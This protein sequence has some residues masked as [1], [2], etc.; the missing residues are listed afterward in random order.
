MNYNTSVFLVQWLMHTAPK[1]NT[2]LFVTIQRYYLVI[3]CSRLSLITLPSGVFWHRSSFRSSL[4]LKTKRKSFAN[5]FMSLNHGGR[6]SRTRCVAWK[7]LNF[8]GTSPKICDRWS[9]EIQQSSTKINS[10]WIPVRQIKPYK[11]LW[12]R[13]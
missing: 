4:A 6:D 10:S 13:C 8:T 2:L 9:W 1:V 7:G 5:L 12:W 3:K 11:I